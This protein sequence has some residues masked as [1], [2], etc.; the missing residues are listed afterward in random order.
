MNPGHVEKIAEAVLYEGYMLYPYRA[1]AVKNQQ[2]WNF[3]VVAPPEYSEQQ[4]GTEAAMMQ[5]EC[6]FHTGPSARLSV[7]VRF[8]QTVDRMVGRLMQPVEALP[9]D[10]ELDFEPADKLDVAGRTW[11]PWQEARERE[12]HALTEYAAS[13]PARHLQFFEF[14]AG[15]E[16]EALR[17]EAGL[18][19]GV[20]IREWNEVS[21]SVDVTVS[22]CQDNVSK[23]S[24]AIR[25]LTASGPQESRAEALKD[26]FLST[27]TIIHL[28]DGEF[29]SLLDPPANLKSLADACA[30]SGTWPVSG[31][32]AG[33]APYHAV[34][35]DHPL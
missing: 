11:I 7:K 5:S 26:S 28:E 34:V 16:V 19:T 25:N 17:D 2:R 30:N 15:S 8:L 10:S 9:S 27:H 12:V 13:I 21:G 6:L 20:A 31:W 33:G 1:S 14:A 32:R 3:G 35:S 18:A 29:I 24:V 4:N 22:R 23:V